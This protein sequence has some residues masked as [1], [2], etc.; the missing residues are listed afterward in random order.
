[1]LSKV[2]ILIW[3]SSGFKLTMGASTNSKFRVISQL[4]RRFEVNV[5]KSTSIYCC[6][7]YCT[8][9]NR[10]STLYLCRQNPSGVKDILRENRTQIY[11]IS[12]TM[13]AFN[14][15]EEWRAPVTQSLVR[16]CFKIWKSNPS[17][18]ASHGTVEIMCLSQPYTS[19]RSKRRA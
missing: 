9:S 19:R 1:M 11:E 16:V 6:N 15:R 3:V 2:Q 8:K 18:I 12:N 7:E 14:C 13:K 17:H 4:Q 5:S 10:R